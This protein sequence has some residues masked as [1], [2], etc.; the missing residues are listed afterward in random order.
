MLSAA[1]VSPVPSR[2]VLTPLTPC[3]V[4]EAVRNACRPPTAE[5]EGDQGGAA[6]AGGQRRGAT[7][8]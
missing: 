6:R 4:L 5:G 3:E 8:G 7:G 1:G 2:T